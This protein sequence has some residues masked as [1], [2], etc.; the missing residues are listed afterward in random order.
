MSAKYGQL[1]GR[2]FY[3]LVINLLLALP[4]SPVAFGEEVDVY[5]KTPQK[6]PKEMTTLDCAKCHYGIFMTI[7]D[8][9][10]AHRFPCRDCHETFHGFRKG[11]KY[12]EVLPKCSSCHDYPHGESP[13]MTSCKTCHQKPH[14]PLASLDIDQ[15]LPYCAK[16]HPGPAT[17]LKEHPGCHSRLS[18]NACHSK[19]H[20][21]IPECTKCHGTPHTKY[22]DNKGC[23]KCHPPHMPQDVSLAVDVS[24]NI[25]A[26]CHKKQVRLLEMGRKAHSKL[27]CVFC[28]S[29][30]HGFI[31]KCQDCHGVPHPKSVLEEFKG[32]QDCHGDPHN[33]ELAEQK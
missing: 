14:A 12:G 24:N 33:L 15:L 32:C 22:I 16:C 11:L 17:Q 5:T 29:E 1:L 7:R 21:N 28:H 20:G 18:C 8:G 2:A 3:L 23:V 6:M 19:R 10:G 9:K 26:K 25:C 31:P 13:D 27:R 4:L 30:K